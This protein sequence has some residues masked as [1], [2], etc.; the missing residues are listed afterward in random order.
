MNKFIDAD[1][2]RAEI[3]RQIRL[4]ELNF[5]ALGGGGQ[6]FCIN[7]LEW[8]LKRI[9]LLQQEHPSLPFN[10][11]EAAEEYAHNNWE[12]NDY[13]TGARE[14]L[15]FDA[16]GHTEKCFK[17]GA[18]WMAGQGRQQATAVGKV[19][20]NPAPKNIIVENDQWDKLLSQFDNGQRVRI[21][22]VKED[23]E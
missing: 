20:T 15:P 6:T 12:D 23:E 19:F 1:R 11:D 5:A 9:G 10:L 8:V 2:L 17:A 13:H 22:L 14:G 7:T 3:K 4:E 18:E 21:F 16:I